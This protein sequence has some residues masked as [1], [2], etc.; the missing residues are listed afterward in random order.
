MKSFKFMLAVILICT[1]SFSLL[2]TGCGSKSDEEEPSPQEATQPEASTEP[3]PENVEA[4]DAK[5]ATDKVMNVYVVSTNKDGYVVEMRDNA[6]KALEN[7][8]FK[9]GQNMKLTL[10]NLEGDFSKCPKIIEEIKAANPDVVIQDCSNGNAIDGIVKPLA[11]TT[12]PVV[13]CLQVENEQYGFIESPEKPGKNITGV[14]TMPAN[15]QTKAFDFLNKLNPINGKKAVLITNPSSFTKD[16]VSQALKDNGIELKDFVETNY[17]ED[18]K[19]F[20]T[21]YNKDP[22]VGWVLYGLTPWTAKKD[23]TSIQRADFIAWE[24]ENNKK[25][26]ISYWESAVTNFMPCGLC[27]DLSA[28]A[29]QAGEIAARILK[30][31]KP[32]DIAV[33]DPQKMNIMLNMARLKANGMKETDIS[34]DILSSA[35]K[36]FTDYKGTT[37]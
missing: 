23:G 21:K 17:I 20:V 5:V 19:E 6:V 31:E 11:G 7:A 37:K 2:L 34:P 12:I 24:K 33:V 22:E 16:T 15:L 1:M 36:V 18:F 35:A 10:I 14:K 25:P 32:G 28:S 30:G 3:S 8:G 26:N 4:S 9:D 13:M 27:V 29:T